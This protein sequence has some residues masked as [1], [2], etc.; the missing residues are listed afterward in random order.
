[1]YSVT[2]IFRNSSV[3]QGFVFRKEVGARG[4]FGEFLKKGESGYLTI[5]D[6]YGC[7][8]SVD[9]GDVSAVVINDVAREYEKAND[10]RKLEQQSL[11]VKS[12]IPI[13]SPMMNV[14]ANQWDGKKS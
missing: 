6:D 5:D 9:V 3:T 4:L 12:G 7:H 14:V 8:A 11:Q 2:F 10:F 1:M 13:M